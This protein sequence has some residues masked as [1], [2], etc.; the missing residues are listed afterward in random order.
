M[1]AL[2]VAALAPKATPSARLAA[3][4]TLTAPEVDVWQRT[5]SCLPAE[6]IKGDVAPVLTQYCRLVAQSAVVARTLADCDPAADFK[7]YAAVLRLS[8][9]LS[10]RILSLARAMRLTPQARIHKA[11]AGSWAASAPESR[12]IEALTQVRHGN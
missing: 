4:S 7:H 8:G 10:G 11:T 9:E 5:V 2:Q 3:P 6:W 12:G 1:A